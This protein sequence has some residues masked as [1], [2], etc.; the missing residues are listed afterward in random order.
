[1]IQLQNVTD[2]RMPRL[3]L[4]RAKHSAVARKTAYIGRISH[5]TSSAFVV[6]SIAF[7]V[8]VGLLVNCYG[9]DFESYYAHCVSEK[10]LQIL[11]D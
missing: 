4:R 10:F 7:Y 11:G 5:K 8:C 6:R 2:G 9:R 3:L 1:M